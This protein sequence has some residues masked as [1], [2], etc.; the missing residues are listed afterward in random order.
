MVAIAV[1]PTDHRLYWC[2]NNANQIGRLNPDG[3]CDI[4]AGSL[5]AAMGDVG[6]DGLAA[7]ALLNTPAG[8]AFDPAG[9]LY[10][11]DVGNF[12]VR[13]LTDLHTRTPHISAFAGLSAADTLG[14]LTSGQS[15]P[16][17][18]RALETPLVGPAAVCTDAAGNVYITEPGTARLVSYINL[19]TD[20]PLDSIVPSAP[21]VRKV[22]PDGMSRV[23]TGPGTGLLADLSSD[24]SLLI[25]LGIAADASGRLIVA[26]GGNNQIKVL[27]KGSF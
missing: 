11:V 7:D 16:A 6:D 27:P 5:D 23:I 24:D 9:T 10:V 14:F 20:T 3:S 26:D 21:R 2:D 22:T 15:V 19:A 8:I 25:P 13:K 12:R 18:G 1:D 4:V 17:D